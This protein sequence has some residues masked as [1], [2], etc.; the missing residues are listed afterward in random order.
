MA[1]PAAAVAGAFVFM[2]VCNVLATKKFFGGKGQQGICPIENP[3]Y[4]SPDGKTF[5][6]WGV[7]YLLETVLAIA[8]AIPQRNYRCFV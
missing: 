4:L 7:I 1:A 5:A 8:S 6:V 2:V 3:T